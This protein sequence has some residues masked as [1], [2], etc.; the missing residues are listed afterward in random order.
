VSPLDLAA[1]VAA[2]AA[3]GLAALADR[4]AGNQKRDEGIGPPP[5]DQR[6]QAEAYE[7]PGREMRAK[8]ADRR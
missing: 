2:L 5:P 3:P 6:V 4:D 7:Q 8:E 1:V